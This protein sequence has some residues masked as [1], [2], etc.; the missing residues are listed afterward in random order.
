MP[1]LTL[2]W[3]LPLIA[4]R[5]GET[6]D[7]PTGFVHEFDCEM[8]INWWPN[9]NGSY[10]YELD[11]VAIDDGKNDRFIITGETDPAL[12]TLLVRGFD[13]EDRRT[14]FLKDGIM[15]RIHEALSDEIY[16]E[17]RDRSWAEYR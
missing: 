11:Y 12:W 14:G 17:E 13:Y 2:D 6:F 4:R 1:N 8:T 3:T 16:S 5:P 9:D 10:G 15:E 7:K